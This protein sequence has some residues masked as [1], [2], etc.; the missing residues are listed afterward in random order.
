[1]NAQIHRTDLEK[2]ISLLVERDQMPT[3]GEIKVLCEKVQ[4][5]I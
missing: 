2:Q 1:M 4:L 3:E 5:Y